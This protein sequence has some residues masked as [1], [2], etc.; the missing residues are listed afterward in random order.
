GAG[1]VRTSRLRSSDPQATLPAMEIAIRTERLSKTF[2]VGFWARRVE[3]VTDLSL[4]VRRGEIFGLLGP[5]GAGKTTS[6][7]ML[8]GFVRP[9]RGT[10]SIA[11]HAAGS[12]PSRM[13]LGYLPENPALYEFLT[14]E[15]YLRFAGRLTGLSAAD[16][17]SRAAGLLER[18]GLADLVAPEAR[19]VELVVEGLPPDLA[20]RLSRDGAR[21]LQ[22]D[23]ST[24]LTFDD[25]AKARSAL[26]AVV[27]SGAP[28]TSFTPHRRTLEELFVA[29]A[30]GK[31]ATSC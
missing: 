4:E 12:L 8:L 18:V 9:T 2:R 5:N 13:R 10:A 3:A 11:G 21:V 17:R 16:A 6:I 19:A 7:K 24:V 31:A 27:A 26:Q 1:C 14:G 28:V 20:E 22:R 23:R 25:Q 29:R 15:E 30:R